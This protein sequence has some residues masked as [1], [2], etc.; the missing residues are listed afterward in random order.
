MSTGPERGMLEEFLDWHRATVHRKV[1]GLSEADARKRLVGSVTTAAGIVKHLAEVERW[2]FQMVLAGRDDVPMLS[3][4]DDPDA[5]F[6]VAGTDTVAGLLA[7]YEAECAISRR[8]VADVPDLDFVAPRTVRG[9]QYSLRWI[10][11]H[12][13]E[14]T[15]RHN[16]H[17][18][19]LREQ[20]DG[21]T[22]E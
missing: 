11:L 21:S 8:L 12:M 6:R 15:A 14:E 10:L 18:D 7:G 5:D 9:K 16:G 22:G 13:L 3:T 17:L 19:I 1:A 20:L 2:W 4:V